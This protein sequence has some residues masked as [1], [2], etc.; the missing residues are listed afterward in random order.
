MEQQMRSKSN[1][2]DGDRRRVDVD[3]SIDRRKSE[4]RTESRR[5]QG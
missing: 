3:V 5:K 4:R 1:R 2:R